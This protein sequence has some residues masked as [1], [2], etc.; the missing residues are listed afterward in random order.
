MNGTVPTGVYDIA[1]TDEIERV[2]DRTNMRLYVTFAS[3]ETRELNNKKIIKNRVR[4][5]VRHSAL[6]L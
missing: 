6:A 1:S 4:V 2:T 3:R 5:R